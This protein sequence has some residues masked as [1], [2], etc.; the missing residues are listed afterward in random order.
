MEKKYLKTLLKTGN[1]LDVSL[2]KE[3]VKNAWY[4]YTMQ[5]YSAIKNK[6]IMKFAV[7]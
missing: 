4:I 1:N 6:N 5:Y 3:W 2:L 7:K